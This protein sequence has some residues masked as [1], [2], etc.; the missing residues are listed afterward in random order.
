MIAPANTTL[1]TFRRVHIR[2]R[3]QMA[4][5]RAPYVNQRSQKMKLA[6]LVVAEITLLVGQ[7]TGFF[8]VLRKVT[9]SAGRRGAGANVSPVK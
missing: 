8:Q 5:I 7:R 6:T 3:I 1:T 9:S 2:T 4:S